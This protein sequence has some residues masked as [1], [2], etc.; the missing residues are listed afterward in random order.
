MPPSD[1]PSTA[2]KEGETP[3]IYKTDESL[4]DVPGFINDLV[5][6]T[7]S[8]AHRPN[9]VLAFAGALSFLAHLAGRRFVGPRGTFPNLYVVA[10]ADSASG[11]D[12]PRKVN[13]HL[14]GI[15]HISQSI[16]YNV[17][18]GQGLEDKL[19]N[20]P[21]LFCQIDEFDSLLREMKSDKV[22]NAAIESLWRTLLT[23]FTTSD[24]SYSTRLRASGANKN[25]GGE[26]IDKPSLSMLATAIPANFYGSLSQRALTSGLLGR[27]LVFESGPRGEENFNS[28][29]TGR[30][31]PCSIMDCVD[32]L[33]QTPPLFGEKG[34]ANPRNVPYADRAAQDEARRVSKEA[35]ALYKAAERAGDEVA[36]SVWG[37]S[38]ELVGK[39]ALLYALSAD[40]QKPAVTAEGFAWAWRLVKSL[41]LRMLD[42]VRDYAAVDERDGKMLAALRMVEKAGKEGIMRSDVIKRLHVS[43]EE[44]NRIEETLEDRGDIIVEHVP[45]ANGR[46]TRYKIRKGN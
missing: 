5:G 40:I 27:C 8:A 23:L 28:G 17:A 45:S 39:L 34:P 13:N 10:L 16:A 26:E 44:M 36:K 22:A 4:L 20:M 7:M 30:A 37:R 2:A 9:R 42:M 3:A 14:A 31:I 12:Y 1:A 41:Q 24:S 38:V 18:S 29:L 25:T 32:E 43:K 11:K 6:F 33:A 35:D 19:S 46:G 15:A 21:S